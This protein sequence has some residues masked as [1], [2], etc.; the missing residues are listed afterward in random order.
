MTKTTTVSFLRH[1]G[2]VGPGDFTEPL[3]IIGC[4]AVGSHIAVLAAK[5]GFH[6]FVLF[7]SDR[8]EPHNLANQAYDVEHINELK[9]EA[10]SK[11][12]RRFNPAIT[13]T[14]YEKLF[15]SAED[16]DKIVGPLVIAT[17]NMSSR[18]D[19]YDTF[20]LNPQVLGVYEI[21]LG[22]DY[23]ECHIINPLNTDECNKWLKTLRDDNEVP[24]G[25]CNLRICTTLVQLV[26]AYAIHSIC[27]RYVSTRE[28][29][30]WTYKFK[31]QF[32]LLDQLRIN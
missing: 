23:G 13:T 9:T 15:T 11:V 17:D 20:L 12:L 1:D 22:F 6:R 18:K 7:D 5:M 24:D 30:D 26:S 27:N 31:T 21:R 4:G 32:S 19:I 3:N 8:V 29:K 14:T 16:K 25:P 28:G 10:L 2:W